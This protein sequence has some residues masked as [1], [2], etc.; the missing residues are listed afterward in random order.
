VPADYFHISFGDLKVGRQHFADFLV[1]FPFLGN[2]CYFDTQG[3]IVLVAYYAAGSGTRYHFNGDGQHA[4]ALETV[5][6]NSVIREHSPL[7]EIFA[8]IVAR[9]RNHHSGMTKAA[10]RP[11]EQ[12]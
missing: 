12:K 6:Q 3:S 11:P 5:P 10:W 1:G 7:L 2:G 8:V 9:E 4:F